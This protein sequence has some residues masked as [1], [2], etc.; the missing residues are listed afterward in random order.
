MR[1]G[2]DKSYK[3]TGTINSEG[4]IDGRGAILSP[5]QCTLF[6]G[7]FQNG[8]KHGPGRVVEIS[9]FNNNVSIKT[10]EWVAG[11]AQKLEE[12][13]FELANDFFIELIKAQK[14]IEEQKQHEKQEQKLLAHFKQNFED[15]KENA[16]ESKEGD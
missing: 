16:E 7:N 14:A 1:K 13:Q 9:W 11:V 6:E 10:G 5:D 12:T 15:K 2:K 3:Y 4:M 8:Q